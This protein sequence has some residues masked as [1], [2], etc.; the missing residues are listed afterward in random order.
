MK[1]TIALNLIIIFI[2]FTLIELIAARAFFYRNAVYH[3][4]STNWLIDGVAK[5][6]DRKAAQ[7]IGNT[8]K[9]FDLDRIF[10]YPES[11]IETKFRNYLVTRY[12]KTFQNVINQANKDGAEV[13]VFWTPTR[14]SLDKNLVYEDY[15]EQ[16]AKKTGTNFLS[17]RDL[18][19]ENEDYVFMLPYDDHLTRFSNHI[20]ADRLTS[21]INTNI[22]YKRK[23]FNCSDIT[24]SYNPNTSALWPVLPEIPYIMSTDEFG[25]R[26]TQQ[27]SYDI[28]N[29]N[30]IIL[31][32][33]FTF[34]PYLSFYDTYPSILSRQNKNWNVI[35]AGVAGIGLESSESLLKKNSKCLNPAIIVIQVVSADI[36][37]SAVTEYNQ[38]NFLGETLNI[39]DIEKS[40]YQSVQ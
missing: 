30:I 8:N 7:N 2:L 5:V 28:N 10:L 4:F 15:F 21:F 6:I 32:P 37:K 34:G 25:F 33:S 27:N 13:L 39:P 9:D 17:M 23:G 16:L 35:N 38:N 14:K 12:E 22:T 29:H 40:F 20:I 18:L 36:K 31:G 3:S 11:E 24:G 26:K 19:L 1:K